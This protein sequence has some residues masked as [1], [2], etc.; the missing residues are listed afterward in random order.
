MQ[1]GIYLEFLNGFINGKEKDSKSDNLLLLII[2]STIFL[3]LGRM[4]VKT[5]LE[6]VKENIVSNFYIK[7]GVREK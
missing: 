4:A 6:V 3:D 5:F 2:I 7:K 1:G